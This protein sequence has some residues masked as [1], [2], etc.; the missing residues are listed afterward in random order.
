[1]INL[2]GLALALSLIAPAG[3]LTIDQ[4]V[5]IA[6]RNA[7]SVKTAISV[8]RQNEQRVR[9][10]RGNLLPQI[11]TGYTY[12]RYGQAQFANLGGQR[13]QFV[14]LDQNTWTNQLRLNIDIIGA[15]KKN[16]AG[17]RAGVESSRNQLEAAE[18]DLSQNVRRNFLQVL[19]TRELVKVSEQGLK[20]IS[21][22]VKQSELQYKSGLIA[23]I[24]V[25]RLKSQEA[26]AEADLINAKNGLQIAKQL[27]NFAM[28]RDIETEF[29]IASDVN[30]KLPSLTVQQLVELGYK[31]RPEV[32]ALLNTNI[33]LDAAKT[34]NESS[35]K[36]SLSLQIQNQQ[37][38]DPAG[39]NPQRE[40]NTTVLQ[41]NVPIYDAGIARA[42]RKQTEEQINQNS[43][44]LS[45]VLL[46][47]SQEV[48]SAITN[49]ENAQARL[50]AAQVQKNLAEE[51]VRIARI[52][53]DAGEGTVLEIIDA[54]T[55]LVTANN[56]VINAQVDSFIAEADLRR[57][58]GA[59][60]I[61]ST[62]KK[63]KQANE[64]KGKKK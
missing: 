36:P 62:Y 13:I 26:G 10:A 28:A 7:F 8:I 64:A 56:S 31:T 53:R 23:K 16:L 24:D 57:A 3:D 30:A 49:F 21:A 40:I 27:L 52:R 58:I 41:L 35:G 5:T 34:F 19:R 14:P 42:R 2:D 54:E 4:A 17:A 6:K 48:R 63:L 44:N 45:Q 22:R 20:N 33:A 46:G 25:D 11:S 29:E 61:E 1:M 32:K 55:Q 15:W 12:L 37:T 38:L 59:D 18:N 47:I 60:D 9:E 51:V 50:K 39:I 43:F